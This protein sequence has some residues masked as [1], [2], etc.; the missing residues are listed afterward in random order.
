MFKEKEGDCCLLYLAS[1]T[2]ITLFSPSSGYL[3]WPLS[4]QREE[5]DVNCGHDSDTVGGRQEDGGERGRDI[6][7]QLSYLRIRSSFCVDC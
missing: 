6:E 1:S 3:S 2:F 4:L 7:A 5:G